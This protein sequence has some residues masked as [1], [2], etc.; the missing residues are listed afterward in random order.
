MNIEGEIV[1]AFGEISLDEFINHIKERGIGPVGTCAICGGNY[2]F[3]GNNPRPVA[4]G[5][6]DRCCAR[7]NEEIVMPARF[8]AVEDSLNTPKFTKVKK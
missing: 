7:R 6:N 2:V 3:G 1:T 5:K 8:K 4:T